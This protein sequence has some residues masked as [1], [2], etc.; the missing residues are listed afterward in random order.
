MRGT[1]ARFQGAALDDSKFLY[2]ILG[3]ILLGAMLGIIA[4]NAWP[5]EPVFYTLIFASLT[6]FALSLLVSMVR[7]S[8]GRGLIFRFTRRR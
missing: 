5:N 8:H 6:S 3:P 2:L 7:L 1:W 4:T